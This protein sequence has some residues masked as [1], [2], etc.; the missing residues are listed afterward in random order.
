M[1]R[2][3]VVDDHTLMRSGIR[4]LLELTEDI[5][6]VAEAGDGEEAILV[7]TETKPDLVLL[8]VRLPKLSGL[9]VLKILDGKDI[10]PP[11]IMLTTF[12]DDEVLLQG[13]Q[14]G[15]KGFLLKDVS[16]ERLVGA[17]RRVMS[18][19]SFFRPALTER[20]LNGIKKFPLDFQSLDLPSPLTNREIEVLAL[21][22]G[23]Y[24]NLEIAKNLG[25][26]E[27]TIKNHVSN[28][29]SKLGVR[30]RIQAVLK[31]LEAGLL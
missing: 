30:D 15:A 31:G 20:T 10:L 26:T 6:V 1:I 16:L 2:V 22:A 19:E 13:I 8:D 25:T 3:V 21:I 24:N 23:G 28:I 12:D 14:S 18:G 7:I 9:N 27:G 4:G 17:I 29:L 11:T 5:C